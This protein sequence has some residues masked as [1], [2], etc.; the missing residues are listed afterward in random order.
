MEENK[1]NNEIK[2]VRRPRIQHATVPGEFEKV[3][4]QYDLKASKPKP[5]ID[6]ENLTYSIILNQHLKKI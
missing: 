1:L 6:R 4:I 3:N 5:V 2:R